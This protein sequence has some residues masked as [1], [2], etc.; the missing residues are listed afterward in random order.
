M[1]L[2]AGAVS[3][4][5]DAIVLV[6]CIYDIEDVTY[7]N[8]QAALSDF[9]AQRFSHAELQVNLGKTFTKIMFGQVG[10]D[11]HAAFAERCCNL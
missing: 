11:I 2:T 9:R 10:R 4:I 5:E 8:I 1:L 6:N 7:E 3:A